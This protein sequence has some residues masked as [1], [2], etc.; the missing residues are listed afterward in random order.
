MYTRTFLLVFVFATTLAFQAKAQFSIGIKGT[1]NHAWQRYQK[2]TYNEATD[3]TIWGYGASLTLD[4]QLSKYFSVGIEPNLIQRGSKCEPGFI[5]SFYYSD[6]QLVANYVNLPVLLKGH[7]PIFKNKLCLTAEAGFSGAYFMSGQRVLIP[8]DTRLAAEKTPLDMKKEVNYNRL[9]Y[10]FD[11]GLGL[12][13][14]IKKSFIDLNVQY[15]YGLK[16][17]VKGFESKNRNLAY[18]L[19][20]RFVL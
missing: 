3:L 6:V 13:V 11:G 5:F 19:G 2:G 1:R 17:V 10:G 18:Q 20:Y 8:K 14:P 4:R 16:D 12:S 7:Y 15:Y 9:D